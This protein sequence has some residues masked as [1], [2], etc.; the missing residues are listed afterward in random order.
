MGVCYQDNCRE[1][2]I[3][4][5]IIFMCRPEKEKKEPSYELRC[6]GNAVT[7]CLEQERQQNRTYIC[8]YTYICSVYVCFKATVLAGIF[9]SLTPNSLNL[10]LL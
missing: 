9:Q 5:I 1:K 10:C 7:E 8:T 2:Y 3:V 4:N 6:R